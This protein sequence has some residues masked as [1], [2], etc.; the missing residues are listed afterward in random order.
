MIG[1]HI[2]IAA[3]EKD[4]TIAALKKINDAIKDN[5]EK[6]KKIEEAKKPLEKEKG[7]LDEK[8]TKI[9]NPSGVLI[10]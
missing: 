7:E 8:K 10:A 2:K 9:V 6:I 3:E 4:I 5:G 1:A